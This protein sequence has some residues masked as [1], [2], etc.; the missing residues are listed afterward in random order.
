MQRFS[1]FIIP[2]LIALAVFVSINTFESVTL[3]QD[4][5]NSAVS[6]D[7]DAYSEGINSVRYDDEGAIH[8]TLQAISQ[9]HYNDDRTEL[10]RPLIRLFQQGDTRWNIV[11][12]SG[13]ISATQT[14][15]DASS[16]IIELLGNVEV[17]SIDEYGNRTV[18]TTDFLSLDPNL[19]TMETDQAVTLVTTNLQQSSIGMFADLKLDEIVF[20][21]DNR[22][23]YEKISN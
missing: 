6:L 16:R 15:T 4:A 9:V 3:V 10:E 17:Y 7:Y 5:H 8:Y 11:A 22:G 2:G 13:K 21:R 20:H 19:E 12:N 18:L 23:S 14:T 1:L